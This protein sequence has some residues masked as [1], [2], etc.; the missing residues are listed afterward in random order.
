MA[1]KVLR[2]RRVNG[3]S[4][5]EKAYSHIQRKIAS[6][7]LSGGHAISEL[8]L[9]KDLGI[10]RTPI[11]EALAQLAAE[12]ILEQSPNR[13]AVVLKL[14]RQDIIDLYELREALEVY[15]VGKAARQ[16]VRQ[17][18]LD[19]LQSLNDSILTLRD[20]LQRSGKSGLDPE[21]MHR[22][23]TYDLAFHTI[24]VRLAA[25]AR[26]LKVVNET[27][28]LVRIFS[29]RRRGYAIPELE[30]IH[31]RHRDVVGGI[32]EQ[33][34]PSA[35]QAISEHIQLSQVERLNDFDHWEIEASL[36]ESIPSPIRPESLIMSRK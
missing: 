2:R 27:R 31:R 6:G 25:N 35:M 13:K 16:L 28:V 19:R 14:E 7:E 29:I 24:L 21:Q 4:A 18:D 11:R 26:L 5:R 15:A 36:R 17:D 22:F 12:G 8:S 3:S 10:S 32:A 23:V 9:A 33:N 20:E 1:R 34:S 30:D